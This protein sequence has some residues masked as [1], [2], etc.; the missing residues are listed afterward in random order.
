MLVPRGYI[1]CIAIVY[2]FNPKL[3]CG[4]RNACAEWGEVFWDVLEQ[5]EQETFK[6]A[7]RTIRQNG[8]NRVAGWNGLLYAAEASLT[9]EEKMT[10]KKLATACL[11][12]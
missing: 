7:A 1:L 11:T 10:L 4:W 8:F 9:V 6:Q 3:R 5:E 2:R 12:E